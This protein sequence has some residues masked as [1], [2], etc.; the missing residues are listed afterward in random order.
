MLVDAE[1]P[2]VDLS[3]AER[4]THAGIS[5]ALQRLPLLRA[6]DLAHCAF[7]P[8]LLASLHA[9]LP[10]AGSPAAGWAAGAGGESLRAGARAVAAAP[11]PGRGRHGLLGGCSR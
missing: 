7:E 6:L 11:A 9:W 3:G 2:S 8:A 5:A 10:P 1:L 4:L